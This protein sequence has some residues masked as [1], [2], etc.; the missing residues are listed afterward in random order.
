MGKKNIIL[1]TMITLI[2]AF[3]LT[4]CG[5]D[6]ETTQLKITQADLDSV[7]NFIKT[8]TGGFFSHGGPEGTSPD[9]TF[10]EV[11]S[12]LTSLSGTIAPGTII[13]KKSYKMGPDGTRT[14]QL[15]VVFVMF[16]RESDYDSDNK[17]WE[18]IMIPYDES[19]DYEAHPYGM[20]P[21][22]GD[23]RGKIS[24]CIN[25]HANALGSD[26]LYSND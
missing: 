22:A 11:Y 17:D 16:K 25:C 4:N 14:D 9:S 10:R 21:G 5:S 24:L 12:T 1:I 26:Y 3:M 19:V 7:S 20:M 13:A 2:T 18:Y 8:A 15:Y 6:H 23:N